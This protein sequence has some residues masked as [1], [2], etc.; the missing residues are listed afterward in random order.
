MSERRLTASED[1]EGGSTTGR[2]SEQS[3]LHRGCYVKKGRHTFFV[4][5]EV[6]E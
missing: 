1:G 5:R 3:G 2:Q 4:Y 6:N